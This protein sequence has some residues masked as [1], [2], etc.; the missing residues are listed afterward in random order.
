MTPTATCL[1]KK[2]TVK[3]TP[4][5]RSTSATEPTLESLM[6]ELK[7]LA[8]QVKS[9]ARQVKSNQDV[10]DT[11][12]NTVNEEIGNLHHRLVD[13]NEREQED[14]RKTKID[15]SALNARIDEIG[16]LIHK[17]SDD[18]GD[19]KDNMQELKLA[20]HE[21]IKATEPY[22]P[23]ILYHNP[24][25]ASWWQKFRK[26]W[27]AYLISMAMTGLV[28]FVVF[29][30][31]VIPRFHYKIFPNNPGI[32]QPGY[33]ANTPAGAASLEVSREP[34]RSD[35]ASRRAFGAIFARLDELVRTGQLT[36]YE[37][38]YNEFGRGMQAG[39]DGTKYNQWAEVWNRIAAVCHRHGNGAYDLRAFND[40]LQSAAKVVAGTERYSGFN[41]PAGT[42]PMPGWNLPQ[43]GGGYQ[44]GPD[45]QNTNTIPT[46]SHF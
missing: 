9:G 3:K 13:L 2:T 26:S 8:E 44:G 34:F 32:L 10:L 36:D 31:F 30:W 11:K 15:I 46:G 35:T 24:T 16:N 12:I 17:S 19:V 27:T 41:N 42:A 5:K 18:V 7:V 33:E 25:L 6:A 45:P 38:Y 29:E 1:C 20:I 40:N 22:T 21:Q 23:A 37:G 14:V 4:A 28:F 43:P 39:I